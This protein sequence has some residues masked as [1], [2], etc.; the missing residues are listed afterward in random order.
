MAKVTIKQLATY[1]VDKIDQ[2]AEMRD[3]ATEIASVLLEER[4]T[5]DVAAVLR[6]IEKELAARGKVQVTVTSV[7]E[8]SE[9]VKMQLASLLGV[10]N[11]VFDQVID[12][13][14]IGGVKAQAGEKQ[15]DL[16]ARARLNK[17][18]Q[19]LTS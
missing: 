16:T 15:I 5:R 17:F 10:E 4:R 11:P 19:Q 6:A 8:V 3:I 1:A 18:K 2:G 9:A 14:V 13:S 12:K 7:H